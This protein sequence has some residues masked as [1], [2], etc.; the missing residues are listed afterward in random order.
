MAAWN[1][2]LLRTE[3]GLS[4]LQLWQRG[5]LSASPQWQQGILD[6]FRVPA[7][8]GI[9]YVLILATLSI[10]FQWLFLK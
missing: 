8:Y 7:D 2:H 3:H 10:I 9:D 4:P 6:G 1:H 5:M